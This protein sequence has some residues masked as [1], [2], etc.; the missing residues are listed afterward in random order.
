MTAIIM[1]TPSV[2]FVKIYIFSHSHSLDET[3]VLRI[4][5][6][7]FAELCSLLIAFSS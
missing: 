1:L 4:I 2:K 6:I 3:C 7:S 5:H